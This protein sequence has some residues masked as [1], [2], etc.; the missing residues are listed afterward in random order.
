V[1]QKSQENQTKKQVLEKSLVCVLESKKMHANKKRVRGWETFL[2]LP[3]THTLFHSLSLTHTL[4]HTHTH[5]HT[6]TRTLH[7]HIRMHT[8]THSHIQAHTHSSKEV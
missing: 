8:H 7:T 3:H 6:H 2:T 5:I 1:E 4:T